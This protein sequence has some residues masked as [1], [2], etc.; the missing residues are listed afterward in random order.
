MK[1]IW[2]QNADTDLENLVEYISEDSNI[3]A[4]AFALEILDAVQ[5]LKDFPKSGRVVPEYQQENTREIIVG[6]YRVV[7]ETAGSTVRVL[8]IIHGARILRLRHEL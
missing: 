8:T 5:R 3:Y 2:T 4:Q 6:H 7:Y 1:I